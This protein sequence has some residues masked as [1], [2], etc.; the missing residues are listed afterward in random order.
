[1]VLLAWLPVAACGSDTKLQTSDSGAGTGGAGGGTGG[2]SGS[3]VDAA[4]TGG[5]G[6]TGGAI[7]GTGGAGGTGGTTATG[8]AGGGQDGGT[9]D[10]G[11]FKDYRR[12]C[13]DRCI[14]TNNDPLHCGACGNKCPADKPFCSGG[15]CQQPPCEKMGCDTGRCCGTMCCGAGQICCNVEGPISGII[16]CHTPSPEQPSCP[17]GCAPLCVAR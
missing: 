3:G 17:P 13:G 5:A 7:A 9:C 14:N 4:V 1:M 16:G 6:G 8:G 15:S 12:C 2:G 11:A 10:C